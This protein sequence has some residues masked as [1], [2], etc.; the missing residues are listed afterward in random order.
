MR[1]WLYAASLVRIFLVVEIRFALPR[2]IEDALLLL[3]HGLAL[4]KLSLAVILRVPL[5]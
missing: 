3:H 5:P 4:S 2:K 1:G